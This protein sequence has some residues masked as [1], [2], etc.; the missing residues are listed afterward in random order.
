MVDSLLAAPSFLSLVLLLVVFIVHARILNKISNRDQVF[1][2][3]SRVDRVS[4][5]RL[6]DSVGDFAW[7][8][9]WTCGAAFVSVLGSCVEAFD[10]LDDGWCLF[11]AFCSSFGELAVILW[12]MASCAYLYAQLKERLPDSLSRQKAFR[13][14]HLAV[15]GVSLFMTLL[16][17]GLGY[18]GRNWNASRTES[19]CWFQPGHVVWEWA[20]FYL[21]L[22]LY[23]G[24]SF[25]AFVKCVQIIRA[26]F[27]ADQAPPPPLQINLQEAATN[28]QR[29]SLSDPGI[30][31]YVRMAWQLGVLMLV[32]L[33]DLFVVL[34]DETHGNSFHSGS[35]GAEFLWK[36]E[37]LALATLYLLNG[38][39]QTHF[40]QL[41]EIQCLT[42]RLCPL[43]YEFYN[44]SSAHVI[45]ENTPP[46]PPPPRPTPP[47]QAHP[48]TIVV[49][50]PIPAPLRPKPLYI[51]GGLPPAAIIAFASHNARQ[52]SDPDMI[53]ELV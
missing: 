36:C 31:L 25:A 1:N 44:D 17:M 50:D 46:P 52:A 13:L 42:K 7:L 4:N 37:G 43:R 16:P 19:W 24:V 35:R 12:V 6:N 51:D 39:I 11:T 34:V 45:A 38:R 40:K 9:F 20:Q 21:P 2:N 53:G 48:V 27:R 18:L 5:D 28:A 41:P 49:P 14:Y 47:Q 26:R 22:V 32:Y 30:V 10:P 29:P 8:Q 33:P 3:I 23:V 15:W